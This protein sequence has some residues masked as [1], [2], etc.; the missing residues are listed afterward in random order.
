MAN[1]TINRKNN[2]LVITKAF[3]KKA[4]IFGSDEYNMLKEA[5]QDNPGFRVITKSTKQKKE[6]NKGLTYEYME[7]YIKKHDNEAK[8]IMAEYKMLR[9][10]DD[11][12]MVE[13]LSYSEMRDWFFDKFPVIAE[14]HKKREEIM[15]KV[16]ENKLQ[17]VA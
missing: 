10:M 12:L 1:I 15:N 6:T 4:N 16:N 9:G 3:E 17:K 8:T 14:F 11:E 7:L 2:T 13:S 5:R